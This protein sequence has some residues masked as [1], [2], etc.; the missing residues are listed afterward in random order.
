[1]KYPQ[2]LIQCGQRRDFGREKAE[3]GGIK[4]REGSGEEANLH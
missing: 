3:K 4:R 2:G 1:M